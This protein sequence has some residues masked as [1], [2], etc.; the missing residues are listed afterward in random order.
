MSEDEKKKFGETKFGKFLGKAG[1]AIT[2]SGGDVLDIGVTAVTQGPAAAI[3]KT[4]DVLRNGSD[5]G[6]PEATD[7]LIELER[8]RQAFTV[9]MA[10]IESDNIQSFHKLEAQQ[11]STSD[12]LTSR[13]RPIR[14]YFWLL[15]IAIGLTIDYWNMVYGRE[16]LFMEMDNPLLYIMAADFGVYT[17][18]RTR[19]KIKGVA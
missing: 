19:E 12:K 4:I 6:N 1:K 14:Q 9:D 15:L 7:L 18:N 5:A 10:K 13:A 11:L 17:W 2:S 16:K 8:N 3:K